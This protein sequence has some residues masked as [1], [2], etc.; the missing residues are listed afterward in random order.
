MIQELS[1][2]QQPHRLVDLMLINICPMLT[3]LFY[4]RFVIKLLCQSLLLVLSRN[5]VYP[6]C[7][8]IC[9]SVCFILYAVCSS[10]NNWSL[11]VYLLTVLYVHVCMLTSLCDIFFACYAF[12]V[13]SWACILLY[14]SL[15]LLHLFYFVF[16]KLHRTTYLVAWLVYGFAGY[17]VTYL[18]WTGG[19]VGW[20]PIWLTGYAGAVLPMWPTVGCFSPGWSEH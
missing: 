2:Y 5:V 7:T 17:L 20:L 13:C 12:L 4:N 8:Y 14:L 16:V 19:L 18:L 10:E 15:H 1:I 3:A 11:V 9:F 6:L